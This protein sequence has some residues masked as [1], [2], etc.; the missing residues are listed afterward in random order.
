MIPLDPGRRLFLTM[1]INGGHHDQWLHD[2]V[3]NH[4][5]IVIVKEAEKVVGGIIY[6]KYSQYRFRGSGPKPEPHDS[7]FPKVGD[8]AAGTFNV[9]WEL[10][11]QGKV[12]LPKTTFSSLH[13]FLLA[14]DSAWQEW[15]NA[16][17]VYLPSGMN[18]F[19]IFSTLAGIQVTAFFN[20]VQPD[21]FDLQT[22]Y[23][24]ALWF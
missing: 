13:D 10:A 14:V 17:P 16:K 9:E 3:R 19:T 2:F 15:Y 20:H 4:P 22:A 23:V 21:D 12:P 6:R 8:A 5:Q 24:E 7:R 1:G 18:R 11:K